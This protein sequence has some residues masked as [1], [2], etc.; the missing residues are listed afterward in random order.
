MGQLVVAESRRICRPVGIFLHIPPCGLILQW[1][2]TGALLPE[3]MGIRELRY[4]SPFAP[5][6]MGAATSRPTI[7][8][9][10]SSWRMVL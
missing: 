9:A 7:R 10:T 5:L 2:H 6:R 1:P 8:A 4:Q 3:F